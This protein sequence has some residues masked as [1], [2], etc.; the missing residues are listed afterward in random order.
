MVVGQKTCKSGE[1]TDWSY[2]G[3]VCSFLEFQREVKEQVMI[4][5]LGK[6]NNPRY[7]ELRKE[8]VERLL[9]PR[10]ESNNRIWA[11][12]I[13]DTSTAAGVNDTQAQRA[14]KFVINVKVKVDIYSEYVTLN[15]TN[16]AQDTT[17]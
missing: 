1:V 15:F 7:R 11:E 6:P 13:V 17:L 10:I 2:I 9:S 5:Q 12:A 8:Q 14:R 16:V 4:P 3:H